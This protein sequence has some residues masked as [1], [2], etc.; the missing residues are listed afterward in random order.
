ML[1]E[2][3]HHA[4]LHLIYSCSSTFQCCLLLW[5]RLCFTSRSSYS[6]VRHQS[7]VSLKAP[8]YLKMPSIT[9]SQG[10]R[11]SLECRGGVYVPRPYRPCDHVLSHD[12]WHLP[13]VLARSTAAPCAEV[14]LKA[15]RSA[16]YILLLTTLPFIRQLTLVNLSE[17]HLA[18]LWYL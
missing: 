17:G 18:L 5:W 8:V 3:L 4:T 14:T 1:R 7:A 13:T 12:L 9:D 15:W 10:T 6:C 2:C 11:G 16:V